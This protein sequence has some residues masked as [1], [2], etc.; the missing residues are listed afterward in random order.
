MDACS[1]ILRS[2]NMDIRKTKYSINENIASR[3][4]VVLGL[5]TWS[6]TRENMKLNISLER[7]LI[8]TELIKKRQSKI[9]RWL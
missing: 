6:T 7:R 4:Y 5:T 9:E 2:K 3:L 1:Y 8:T